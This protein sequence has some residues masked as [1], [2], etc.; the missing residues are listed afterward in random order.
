MRAA[1]LSRPHTCELDRSY[2]EDAP[3]SALRPAGSSAGTGQ[4]G[5]V[6]VP[7][8]YLP[9]LRGTDWCC[10]SLLQSYLRSKALV[11]LRMLAFNI[12]DVSGKAE[13]SSQDSVTGLG[14]PSRPGAWRTTLAVLHGVQAHLV[15]ASPPRSP[16]SGRVSGV[17][18]T[19][20]R[21]ADCRPQRA[22]F[23]FERPLARS[24]PR[25]Y[26]RRRCVLLLKFYVL[27]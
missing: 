4:A 13:S 14:A 6:P 10:L 23:S 12:V 27:F 7:P 16:S 8:V 5:E 17:P 24:F 1:V 26:V 3:W 22:R 21:V 20:G 18:I 11:P 25:G 9:A 15:Q 19:A 2:K